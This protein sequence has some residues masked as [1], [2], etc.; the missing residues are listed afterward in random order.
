MAHI[1]L[2]LVALFSIGSVA[3]SYAIYPFVLTCVAGIT[4]TI[5]DARYV[6]GKHE[7]RSAGDGNL[8]HV[9]VVISAFNEE[10]HIRSRIENLL[11]LD[12]PSHL[13][14]VYIGSDGSTDRTNEI[15]ASIEGPHVHIFAFEENRGKSSVLNDLADRTSSQILIFSDANTYFDRQALRRLVTHFDDALVGAVSG[16]LRLKGSDGDNQDSLYWRLEQYLKFFE[17]RIGGL[18]G[19]NGAIYAIRRSL[20]QPLA[21]DTICDDFCIA[22]NV[23][24][25]GYKLVYEPTAWAEEDTPDAIEEEYKRRVRIG[26]GN[27]QSLIRHPEYFFGT[28]AGTRF[29]YLSHKILRWIAPHLLIVGLLVSCTLAINSTSWR[30][31]VVVQ[32]GC[33]LGAWA[34]YQASRSGHSLPGPLRILAFLFALN[35]ALLVASFRYATGRYRGAW[36]RTNR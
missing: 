36:G 13:L 27:F 16:E 29:T 6:L 30:I 18:L 17:A 33:Y 11:A 28:S 15:L 26:I 8:P 34:T 31:A 24:A 32:I 21:T 22:M 9:A 5:R 7:R 10:R 25:S 4:Q 35:W 12:Y 23:A 2:E 19:A 20:W 14:E 1:F 3:Y